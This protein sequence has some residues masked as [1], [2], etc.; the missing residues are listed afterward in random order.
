MLPSPTAALAAGSPPRTARMRT[1]IVLAGAVV[2]QF[3]LYGPALIGARILLPLDLLALPRFYLPATPEYRAV[4]PHDLVFTDQVLNY[5]FSRRFAAA[6]F[7]AGRLPLW[8]PYSFSGAPFAHFGKYCPL[9]LVYYLFPSPVAL[10]W[11]QLLKAV[12]SAAGAY[13]FFRR[14]LGVS[15]WPAAVGAACY[16]LTGF[17][18]FWQ[19]YPITLVTAFFPWI[20]LASDHAFR[21]PFGWGM[22]GLALATGLTITAGHLDIAGQVLLASGL[23]VLLVARSAYGRR[24]P[25]RVLVWPT[26]ATGAGWV[27]GFL[28]AAPYLL[29]LLDYARTGARM[30]ERARGDE[31]RPPAGL[32]ALPLLVLPD[33]YGS[34]RRGF[35]P[36]SREQET[37]PESA[38]AGYTGLVAT[39]FLAP[40]AWS[41]RRH[42]WA[43][44]SWCLLG[45]F[46]L[47]WTLDVPGLV[48]VLRMPGLNM[49]SHNRLVFLTS[50][51]LLVLAVIGMEAL[52]AGMRPGRGWIIFMAAMPAGLGLLCLLWTVRLP[53]PLVAQLEERLRAARDGLM[54]PALPDL[55]QLRH[56]F[57]L[58]Y[59]RGAALC[60]LA[61]GGW[62][63]TWGAQPRR[64]LA[65]V[66]GAVMLAEL[67]G[68]ARGINP[69]A[70]PA[71]YY[72][73]IPALEQLAQAPP[74]R[75]LGVNCLP[76]SLGPTVGL[77]DIRG[78]DG[79]DPLAYVELLRAIA[80][81][82]PRYPSP[83]FA[84]TQWFVPDFGTVFRLPSILDMLGVR[85]VI[86]RGMPRP[87]ARPFAQS[88]DYWIRENPRALP[89]LF[90]PRR[91]LATPAGND[92]A[93][94]RL[95]D[96]RF[97][98]R[99]VAYVDAPPTLPSDCRGTAKIEDERPTRLS[100]S[101]TMETPG[102]LILAD[103]WE[104]GWKATVN[105]RPA[106]VLRANHILRAVA[107]PAGRSR[108]RF[109]YEPA[110]FALGVKLFAAALVA[111]LLWIPGSRRLGPLFS[112]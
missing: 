35:L 26:I 37:Q 46:G 62:I 3:L 84:T 9:Y 96:D 99:A 72:P 4:V 42:R 105:G 15:F 104:A 34:L 7:R 54:G 106:P 12:V 11:I 36:V 44:L 58:V 67:L 103:C 97:D 66:A 30:K 10:A 85:Y 92:G 93:L 81:P 110:S 53:G 23:Y 91:V 24:P 8:D 78:Y 39:L 80:D 102:L 95:A 20:L 68:F 32:S 59:A 65:A 75:V 2:P 45:F 107:L 79:I 100:V 112:A 14:A 41:S 71:L 5:E 55:D 60:L 43:I 27:L 90:V 57:R 98:P 88:A 47:A 18:I 22:P 17:S 109:S 111:I 38:A 101:A 86:F 82:N 29:P 63:L 40:L 108:V 25:A 19:G 87:R 28:L 76:A 51:A 6:E 83:R 77:H 33:A 48:Q 61:V 31:E 74:G 73:P 49:M 56:N 70:D 21:R 16:P 52:R 13:H 64:W 50:F 1:L 94:H 69:Q 89:R